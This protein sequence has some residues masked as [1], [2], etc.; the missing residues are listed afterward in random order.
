MEG[1]AI[2]GSS[3]PCGWNRRAFSVLVRN[4]LFG[5]VTALATGRLDVDGIE[6]YRAEHDRI[7]ID[8]EARSS[9][10]VSIDL[11]AGRAIQTLSDPEGHMEWRLEAEIDLEMSRREDR[12]VEFET[13]ML[14]AR[15]RYAER[16]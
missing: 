5:I 4:E 14:W 2:S 12:A 3:T 7:E 16:R 9:R 13:L 1:K 10:W 6:A 15:H 8:A 11:D